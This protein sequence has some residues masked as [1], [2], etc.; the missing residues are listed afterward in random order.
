LDIAEG[1]VKAHLSIAYRAIDVKN[2][3]E[4]VYLAAKLN[5]GL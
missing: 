5:L 2:R 4:A 1:T 3:T